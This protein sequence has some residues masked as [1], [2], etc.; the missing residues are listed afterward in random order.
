MPHPSYRRETP[1]RRRLDLIQAT[2]DVV[3]HKGA[4]A[5]TVRAISKQAGVS[6]GLIRHHFASKEDLLS[7]AFA[8]HMQSL[9]DQC[10][11]VPDHRSPMAQLD[12]FVTAV[13]SPPVTRANAVQ[14]WAGFM[15][16]VPRD[17]QM[18]QVHLDSYLA[19]RQVLEALILAVKTERNEP[20]T[21]QQIQHLAIACNAVLDGL[22]LEGSLL[23]DLLSHADI[24]P[25]AKR[26][27]RSILDQNTKEI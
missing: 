9:T 8:H 19:F 12:A 15:Q 26:T 17:P 21:T 27:I 18:K 7:A 22:W 11:L 1:E 10:V 24:I 25:I 3:A 14:I 20:L 6:F 16:M 2:L 5:A 4:E 13:L 23:P